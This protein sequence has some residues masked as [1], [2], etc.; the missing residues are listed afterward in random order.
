MNRGKA[1]ARRQRP[2]GRPRDPSS[3]VVDRRRPKASSE[4][5]PSRRKIPDEIEFDWSW[6]AAARNNNHLERMVGDLLAEEL[7]SDK[8]IPNALRP[9]R[10]GGADGVYMG[11]IAGVDGP[12]LVPKADRGKPSRDRG[13]REG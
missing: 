13:L 1:K 7:D 2:K 10:D 5:P 3:P 4:A 12:R 9:G 8:F 11:R 6:V